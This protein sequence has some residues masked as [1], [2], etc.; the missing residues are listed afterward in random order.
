VRT[1]A[2]PPVDRPAGS[3]DNLSQPWRK[4]YEAR[5][6][7]AR[8]Q[9]LVS[10]GRGEAER[11]AKGVFGRAAST[12]EDRI[13]AVL[14][15]YGE[16]RHSAFCDSATEGACTY[17]SD[18][19]P[20]QFDGP[21]HNQIPRPNR[22]V[23]NTTLWKADYNRNH[24]QDMYFNRMRTFY[25]EQSLGKY[26]FSGDVTEW[27]KVPYNQARYGRDFC[28]D[29]VCTN[30]FFLVRDALSMWTQSKLDAGWSM[31][32]IQE[33]LRTFDVEDRYDFDEDGDFREPDGY[34]DHFQIVHAGGD[35]ADADPSYGSDAIWSHRANAQIVPPGT[36]P[37]GGAQIGGVQIGAGG[38]SDP[39]GSAVQLPD[40]PTGVWVN[41][42]TMQPENGG[43]SVFA[44]EYAHDLGLPDLYD[45]SG[46]AGGAENSTGFWTLMSQSRGTAVSDWGIGDRPMPFGAWE[47]FQLG[48]LDYSVVR[49]G[50]TATKVLR[51]AQSTSTRADN[52]LIVLLPDKHVP[53]ELGAPCEGCGQRY[54]YSGSGDELDNTMT[55]EVAGGGPLTAQVRYD[56]E[57]GYDYAF[58][59]VSA[60]GGQSWRSIPTSES[61]EDEDQGGTNPEGTG[62]SG[63]STGWVQL[64][65][66]VPDGTNAIRWRYR[67]DTAL[68]RPGFQVDRITLADQVIGDAETDGEGWQLDGFRTTTGTEDQRFLHAYFVDNRQYVG[69]DKLLAH[70]YNAGFQ[71]TDRVEF[72]RYL[73][74]A[75]I[76]YW[77][78]SYNDNN[79]GEHPGHGEVLPVDARPGFHHNPDGTLV[80]PRTTTWDATFSTNNAQPFSLHYGGQKF[81]LAGSWRQPTFDDTK[82]WWYDSDEHAFTG[83]HKGRYQP[84]W[85]SVDVPKTGTTIKVVKVAKNGDMTVQVGRSR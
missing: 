76:T 62:I 85:Y 50:R 72:F 12:G 73:P 36:G 28:G 37:E 7:V 63:R 39:D 51:P 83:E 77:D 61:Y 33:Y 13:F 44:H 57:G 40:N 27:V 56:I 21:L 5:N 41:D 29:L 59:E 4:K 45:T 71:N 2:A 19:S 49:A 20:Q 70:V 66:T 60:D 3:S 47:K 58:L 24:Y 16:K 67:T 11:L 14:V 64:T 31:A 35:Q 84:G 30:V 78:S 15:E 81:T 17:P 34:V 43:L 46:N 79:V 68:T 52:G 80:R 26:T 74:G 65:A 25:R 8:Q 18:G 69:R 53:L 55:R 23:D 48:W 22:Q 82:D 6:D 42:Y 38:V 32:R 1:T 75:L 10:G 9:R 54:F